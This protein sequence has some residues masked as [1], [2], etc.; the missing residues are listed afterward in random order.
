MPSFSGLGTSSAFTVGLKNL[1]NYYKNIKTDPYKLANFSI[2]FE[3][4][5][6]KESVGFQDQIHE[7]YGGLNIIKFFSK[8][9]FKVKKI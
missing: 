3:R 1:I 2:N 8:N 4:N 5:I 9:K 6:L 7:S